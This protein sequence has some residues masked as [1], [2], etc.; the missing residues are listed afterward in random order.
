MGYLRDIRRLTVAMSRARLGLYVFGRLRLF[1]K[2]VDFEPMFKH[3]LALPDKLSLQR[4]E[5][6]GEIDRK[7]EDHGQP[8]LIQDVVEMGQLVHRMS[9]SRFA[10]QF[11][12]AAIEAAREQ[13]ELDALQVAAEAEAMELEQEIEALE[14]KFT[15]HDI[16]A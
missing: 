2:C 11:A 8:E 10:N 6:Y 12:S 9:E 1:A 3:F 15:P 14:K 13:A 7:L 5:V 4:N 16:E